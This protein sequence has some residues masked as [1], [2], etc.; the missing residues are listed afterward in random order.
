MSYDLL[1]RSR[2]QDQVLDALLARCAEAGSAGVLALDLDGCLF[3]NRPRQV[4][5][6]RAWAEARGET[7]LSGLAIHHYAD[8]DFSRTLRN[9]GLPADEATSLASDFRPFWERWFF[10]DA[11]VHHDLPLPGAPRFV[12]QAAETGVHVAYVTGRL[13]AQA[14][15]TLACLETYGFPVEAHGARLVAKPDA[16]EGDGPWKRRAFSELTTERALTGF[17]DNEPGHVIHT[18]ATY[19][20]AMSVWMRTDHSPGAQPPAPGT[21]ELHGWLRSTDALPG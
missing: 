18:L 15:G 2:A 11:F 21:P 20:D 13:Q 12:R 1:H 9:L 10:D 8:W 17:V 3:D 19:P 6:A 4:R 7:C 16:S 5:I 14:P